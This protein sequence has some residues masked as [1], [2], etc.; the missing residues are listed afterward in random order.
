MTMHNKKRNAGLLYE[1]LVRHMSHALLHNDLDTHRQAYDITVQHFSPGTELRREF[2]VFNALVQTGGVSPHIAARIIEEARK[3]ISQQDTMKL[4]R[5]K[6]ALIKAINYNCGAEIYRRK[7]PDYKKFA[8]IQ[9]IFNEWRTVESDLG[10]LAKFEQQ[11][12]EWLQAQTTSSSPTTLDEHINKDVSNLVLNI[13]NKKLTEKYAKKL[14]PAQCT[15]LNEYVLWDGTSPGL[16]MML[17][18][19]RKETLTAI[20]ESL[21]D[22]RFCESADVGEYVS[23]KLRNAREKITLLE[24]RPVDDAAITRHLRLIELHDELK[25]Q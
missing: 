23:S 25:E 2:R 13:A 18:N 5:E 20:D 7:V 8:T 12:F 1:F 16:T 10:I 17:E 6:S 14:S 9:Q 21:R 24:G 11:L 19:V 3:T 22:Q 15:L 4:E